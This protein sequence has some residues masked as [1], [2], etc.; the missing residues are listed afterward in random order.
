M[1]TGAIWRASLLAIY[2]DYGN[3]IYRDLI[4]VKIYRDRI[5]AGLLRGVDAQP[6]EPAAVQYQPGHQSVSGLAGGSA[7]G[8]E[9]LAPLFVAEQ[10]GEGVHVKVLAARRDV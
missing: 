6:L 3:T 4:S 5:M 1:R 8:R 7:V 2:R 9:V 10:R